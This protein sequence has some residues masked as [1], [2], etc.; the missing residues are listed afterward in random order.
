MVPFF[1]RQRS[2]GIGVVFRDHFGVAHATLSM[3]FMVCWGLL[4]LKPKLWRRGYDLLGIRVS[5][6]QSLK[7]TP[8]SMVVYNSLTSSITLPSSICNLITGSLLQ[9]S[10]F[11]ECKFSVV[12]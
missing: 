6:L 1:E 8:C 2:V 9:A 3:S 4:K 7:E 12:P 5:V 10:W 11:G